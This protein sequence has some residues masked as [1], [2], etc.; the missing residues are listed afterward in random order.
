[1]TVV[2]LVVDLVGFASGLWLL[3]RVPTCRPLSPRAG[4]AG[5]SD[6]GGAGATPHLVSVV[7]PARNEESRLPALLDSLSIQTH[8][9]DQII[10]VDDGSTDGTADIARK[11]GAVVVTPG[12]PPPGWAGKPWACW[13]GAL[14]AHGSTL[15]FLDAD[16]VLAPDALARLLRE[17]ADGGGLLSVQPYHTAVGAVEQLSAFFN[18]V[19]MMGVGAFTPA[20]AKARPN[21]AF[22]PCL[23]CRRQDY[24]ASGGHRSEASAVLD[25]FALSRAFD[26]AGLPVR[27]LG[28]RGAVSFRMYADGLGQ[29]VEGWSKNFAAG[30][31][32][33]STALQ[34]LAMVWTFGCVGSFFGLAGAPTLG[35]LAGEPLPRAVGAALYVLYMAQLWWMLRRIGSFSWWAWLL[36]P[37]PLAFFVA[38]FLRSLWLTLVRRRVSWRGRDVDLRTPPSGSV[39]GE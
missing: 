5:A 18:V 37:V 22:G 10:V 3:W 6:T 26:R 20:G 29:M 32:S 31:G 9:A 24:L 36:Y 16:V 34:L 1:M 4:S 13:N 14:A 19:L 28:G 38:I 30:A 27:C 7:I 39:S 33:L 23:V 2:D 25:D 35:D 21:G 12:D 15:V 17:H 8:R 11:S